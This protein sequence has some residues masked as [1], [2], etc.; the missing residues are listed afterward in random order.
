MFYNK[1]TSGPWN[2]ATTEIKKKQKNT[3]R[4]NKRDDREIATN[5]EIIVIDVNGRP[6]RI[7]T[8]IIAQSL[9]MISRGIRKGLGK[10][11]VT[12]YCD[13]LLASWNVLNWISNI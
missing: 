13:K 9:P 1:D 2:F 5:E 11:T 3:I 10:E 6:F 7:V 4:G 8:I 12:L